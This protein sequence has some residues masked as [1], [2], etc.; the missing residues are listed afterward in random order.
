M[1]AGN[2]PSKR[3]RIEEPFEVPRRIWIRVEEEIPEGVISVP[4]EGC[5]HLA[6][7]IEATQRE[8][9]QVLGQTSL[10][11]I[12]LHSS[13]SSKPLERG[14]LLSELVTSIDSPGATSRKPL[15][16][17]CISTLP[18]PSPPE[19]SVM[20]RLKNYTDLPYAVGDDNTLLFREGFVRMNNV[21]FKE[22]IVFSERLHIDLATN[23][24]FY[25]EPANVFKKTFYGR[26]PADIS[27][28]AQNLLKEDPTSLL[29]LAAFDSQGEEI[30]IDRIINT[31]SK[32]LGPFDTSIES[33]TSDRWNVR[34]LVL[35]QCQLNAL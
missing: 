26:N 22:R 7:L 21:A 13:A 17:K 32:A 23:L 31:L 33:F 3:A 11:C 12:T 4:T 35:L 6:H 15:H 16:L 10:D 34:F 25:L 19:P 30:W 2:P 9:P 18:S 29:H 8:L 5:R 27:T 14:T 1:E 20:T 24:S 28:T